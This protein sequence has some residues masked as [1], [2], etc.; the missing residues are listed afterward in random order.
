[1]LIK[2]RELTIAKKVSFERC[3]IEDFK[4]EDE[5]FDVIFSSLALHY[6]EDLN[7]TFHKASKLLK[8]K[9]YF[10]YSVEHP[11]FTSNSSQD[12][13]YQNGEIQHWPL[14]NYF[15]EGLRKTEFLGSEVVKYHRTLE[16]H[17]TTLLAQGFEIRSVSEPKPSNE[18]IEKMGWQDELRRPMM[19]IITAMKK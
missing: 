12:W 7:A 2:A 18:M 10:C 8:S 15:H 16:T 6:V 19:L 14:D 9:G 3:A 17:I 1:M 4:A 13:H 11:I 5:S